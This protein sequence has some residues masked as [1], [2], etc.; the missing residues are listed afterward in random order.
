[1]LTQARKGGILGAKGKWDPAPP[2]ERRPEALTQGG[3][4]GAK[5]AKKEGAMVKETHRF[6]PFTEE[7]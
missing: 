4:P 2:P 6:A 1:M 5:S 7:L 3:L